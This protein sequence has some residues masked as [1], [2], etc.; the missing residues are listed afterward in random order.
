MEVKTN[1][2]KRPSPESEDSYPVV[3]LY[4]PDHWHDEAAILMNEAGRKKLIEALQSGATKL[5]IPAFVSDGEGYY[6][7]VQVLPIDEIDKHKSPYTNEI[8]KNLDGEAERKEPKY[9]F[10]PEERKLIEQGKDAGEWKV[11]V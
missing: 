1:Y 2:K 8:C 4:S 7:Y 3:Q 6:L 10:T 11:I 9:P 5:V